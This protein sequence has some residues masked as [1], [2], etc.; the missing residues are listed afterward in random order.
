M[1]SRFFCPQRLISVSFSKTSVETAQCGSKS[2]RPG[3]SVYL[4]ARYI[5]W[6]IKSVSIGLLI[7]KMG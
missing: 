3:S 2:D 6:E 4:F 7:Y 1:M 5:P